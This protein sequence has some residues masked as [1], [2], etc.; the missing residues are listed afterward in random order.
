MCMHACCVQIFA[1]PWT[2]ALQVLCPRDFPGKNT[3]VLLTFLSPGDRPYV[4]KIKP[5]SLASPTVADGF[6][7]TVPPKKPYYRHRQSCKVRL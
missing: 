2:V 1:T 7:T 6:F 4:G 5:T 3:G